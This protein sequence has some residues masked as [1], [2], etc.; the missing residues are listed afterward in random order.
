MAENLFKEK[1]IQWVALTTTILAVCAGLSTLKGSSNSTKTQILTTRETN[2]WSY[3]QSKSIK[4]HSCEIQ[5]DLLEILCLDNN[6]S[7]QSKDLINKKLLELNKD[8][9]RYDKEKA[10][11][12][13]EAE[14]LSLDEEIF[15]K[16]AG[17]FH[18]ATMFLQISIMLSS[19]SALIKRKIIWYLGILV[20]LVGIV[21]MMDG[22]LIIF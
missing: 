9:D 4:Q 13:A 14:Q 20:G 2:K 11:I 21:Y 8:I 12:K 1:W 3:F 19:I 15:K 17:G 16:H 7:L 6:N 18:L 5:R 22:F 10:Q